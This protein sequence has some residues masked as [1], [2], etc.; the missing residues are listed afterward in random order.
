MRDPA[1]TTFAFVLYP[2]ATSLKETR[3][4]MDELGTFGIKPGLVVANYVLSAA[5]ASTPFGQVRRAMQAR[6]LGELPTHFD[7]PVL[8]IPLLPQEIKGL[9]LLTELGEALYGAGVAAASER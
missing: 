3:R 4:A 6:Y 1:A 9:A 2:E 5:A 7:A 8:P